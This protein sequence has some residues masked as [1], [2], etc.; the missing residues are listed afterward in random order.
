MNPRLVV[1][2]CVCGGVLVRILLAGTLQARGLAEA[3]YGA[4]RGGWHMGLA[5]QLEGDE[6]GKRRQQLDLE[7][8]QM[9]RSLNYIL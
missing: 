7:R 8:P 3:T 9:L 2:V 1:S 6:Y 4:A 5:L